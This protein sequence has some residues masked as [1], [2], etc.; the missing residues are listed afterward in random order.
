MGSFSVTLLST[1][2]VLPVAVGSAILSGSIVLA[3]MILPTVTTLVIDALAA[4]PDSYPDGSYALG[5]T[6]WQTV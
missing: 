1:L 2:L 6:R 5:Y 3:V 4:V